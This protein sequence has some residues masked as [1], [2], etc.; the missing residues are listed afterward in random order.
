MTPIRSSMSYTSNDLFKSNQT[1]NGVYPV[2]LP[3]CSRDRASTKQSA[4]V[5]RSLMG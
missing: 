4:A 3:Q 2:R 5:V 1:S